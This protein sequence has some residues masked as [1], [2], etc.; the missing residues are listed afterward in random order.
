ME[1]DWIPAKT[2]AGVDEIATRAAHLPPR[3]RTLLI[4][5]D[6]RRSVHALTVA[7]AGFGNA[8]EA[9]GA[10]HERA[11]IAWAGARSGH[12]ADMSSRAGLAAGNGS[13]AALRSRPAPPP[14]RRR[15]LALARLYLINAM[16]QSLRREDQPIRECLRSATSRAELLQAFEVCRE[17]AIELGVGHIDTIEDQFMG[18]LP[19][20]VAA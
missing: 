13:L 18:M 20:E 1:M 6:G 7:T 14:A 17:V 12:V 5:V 3:L 2:A 15:S 8:E 16:E 11:L 4:L 9:L 10:L 19:E